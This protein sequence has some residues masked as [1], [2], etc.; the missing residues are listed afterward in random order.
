WD[1]GW[2]HDTLRYFSL[3]PIYRKWHHRDLSFGMLYAWSENFILP[4]SHDEVVHGKGSMLGKMP[5]D[6]A[7]RFANL[8]ALYG[9]M[10]ARP[11]K[12]L[13]FMGS[14]LGQWAEWNHDSSVEWHVLQ[15]YEH[16]GVKR[17]VGDL[18]RIYREEPALFEADAEPAGFQWIDPDDA[19]NNVISFMRIAPKSG[20]KLICVCNFSAVHRAHFR[21]GVP[22]GGWYREILNTDAAI[23][24]GGNVGNLG[25]VEAAPIP[26]NYREHSVALELPP[27]SAIWL[28]AP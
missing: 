28:A 19:D 18:N 21:V 26:W 12:K 8:R 20:R 25:G 5:G 16:A 17:L 11:G 24:G 22:H 6:R 3:D 13:L 23:Y 4:L 10:W 9:Y 2:M 7:Q 1:M 14:E 27:L 15:G